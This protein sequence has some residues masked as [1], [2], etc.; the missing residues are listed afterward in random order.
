MN[1]SELSCRYFEPIEVFLQAQH[2]ALCVATTEES[3]SRE[4]N[5]FFFH[6]AERNSDLLRVITFPCQKIESL[7][8]TSRAN[9]VMPTAYGRDISLAFSIRDPT[10]SK[11]NLARLYPVFHLFH[12]V[13]QLSF[14]PW[15]VTNQTRTSISF[16]LCGIAIIV[17]S[18]LSQSK[19]NSPGCILWSI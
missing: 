11:L 5:V 10:C 1:E 3:S 12:T 15:Y 19:S 16:A 13:L 7:C 18:R 6:F 8:L 4:G 2:N 14:G 9:H 17:V